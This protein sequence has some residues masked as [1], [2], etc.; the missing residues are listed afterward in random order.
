MALQAARSGHAQEAIEILAREAAQESSGRG[1]FRRRVQLAQVC[2][3]SGH[4][5]I[6][7][8]VLRDLAAEI[9]RRNL[10]QWETADTIAHPLALLFR[11]MAKMDVSAEEKQKIYGM[12]CRLDPVQA[13]AIQK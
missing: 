12:V 5:S 4:N 13:L 10:E 9:E 3:G 7:Y 1:R 6:A 8:P 11:C 2:M